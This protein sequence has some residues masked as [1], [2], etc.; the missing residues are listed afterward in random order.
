MPYLDEVIWLT[1][2]DVIVACQWTYG[3]CIHS[4]MPWQQAALLS[5]LWH[6]W[7]FVV[8]FCVWDGATNQLMILQLFHLGGTAGLIN[9]PNNLFRWQR[10]FD[11]TVSSW[12]FMTEVIGMLLCVLHKAHGW[13]HDV[14][15][16][17]LFMLQNIFDCFF[18]RINIVLVLYV[19]IC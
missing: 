14:P 9:P 17:M 6:H 7:K 13:H 19:W 11:L 5:C 4:N 3:T 18:G 10:L 1:V 15:S 2:C 16:Q 8:S 12:P